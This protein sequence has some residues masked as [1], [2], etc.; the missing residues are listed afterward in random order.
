V[1]GTDYLAGTAGGTDITDD[2]SVGET[3][4]AL[5]TDLVISNG[6][7]DYAAYLYKLQVRGYPLLAEQPIKYECEDATSIARYGRR[8]K[9]FHNP[10]IMSY[11]HA[12]SLGDLVLARFK[13]P[14]LTV[15][16]SGVPGVPHLEPGDR[17]TITETHT[18]INA[19][20]YIGEI[21]WRWDPGGGGL[22][23]TQDLRLVRASDMYP[24][25]DYF[26]IGTSEF[27]DTPDP[28]AGRL[29]W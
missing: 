23:Y 25:S 18:G 21:D 4:K 12:Q 6:N 8:T 29:F 11:R 2:I 26:L 22:V 7:P 10:Y 20:F 3:T 19:D 13:D 14:P 27:G 17:V 24:N 5:Y 9:P 1:A 28:Q 16:L 15:N